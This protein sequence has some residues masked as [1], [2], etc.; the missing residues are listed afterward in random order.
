MLLF[1]L[2]FTTPFEAF[3]PDRYR[4]IARKLREVADYLETGTNRDNNAIRDPNGVRVGGWSILH[5]SA[6]DARDTV[7][8][9]RRTREGH[10]V[11]RVGPYGRDS[12]EAADALARQNRV[13]TLHNQTRVGGWGG[14]GMQLVYEVHEAKEDT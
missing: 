12:A 3:D 10:V 1:N 11:E 4:D 14:S 5:R 2:S 13:A 7:Y 9:E 6:P 8:I